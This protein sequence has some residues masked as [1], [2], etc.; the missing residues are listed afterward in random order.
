MWQPGTPSQ[1]TYVTFP[2]PGYYL[3]GNTL[4][5]DG[6]VWYVANPGANYSSILRVG[7]TGTTTSF[8]LVPLPGCTFTQISLAVTGSVV[9]ADNDRVWFSDEGC[10]NGGGIGA[11]TNSGQV[12][13]LPL[14]TDSNG[15]VREPLYIGLVED[16]NGTIWFSEYVYPPGGGAGFFA[17]GEIENAA[18]ALSGGS[19]TVTDTPVGSLETYAIVIGPKNQPWFAYGGESAAGIGTV[20]GSG[21]TATADLDPLPAGSSENAGLVSYGG[22]LY[23]TGQKAVY[24]WKVAGKTVTSTSYPLPNQGIIDDFGLTAGGDGNLY[25]PGYDGDALGETL[26]DFVPSTQTFGSNLSGSLL[27]QSSYSLTRGSDGNIWGGTPE[28]A[29]EV[30]VYAV[31]AIQIGGLGVFQGIPTALLSTSGV[32]GPSTYPITAT[33]A[34]TLAQS[35][36]ATSEDKTVVT[37]SPTGAQANTGVPITFTLTAVGAGTTT[38]KVT[39]A[40]KNV[41]YVPVYVSP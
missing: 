8:A 38:I 40:K 20:V 14:G 22:Y 24:R 9:K 1:F 18:T 21:T 39:D 33:E 31:F 15:N 19:F 17:I 16:A 36:T 35:L 41:V 37:V 30:F 3:Y 10:G 32:N 2:Q 7:N 12:E 11:V 26:F 29:P 4:G 34:N 28:G 6:N 5:S 13:E 25:F 23:T 27:V